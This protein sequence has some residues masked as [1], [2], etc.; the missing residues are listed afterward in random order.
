MSVMPQPKRGHVRTG[1][2]VRS[3]VPQ[4][5]AGCG[6][7]RPFHCARP[8]FFSFLGFLVSFLRSIPLA[9]EKSPFDFDYG[10]AQ[11]ILRNSF[12]RYIR[13]GMSRSV[14]WLASPGAVL[15]SSWARSMRISPA[16]NRALTI[17][18]I[19]SRVQIS[20]VSDTGSITHT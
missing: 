4:F 7:L 16:L 6:K 5:G 19:R 17:F 20:P 2:A 8:Y 9:I 14:T 3:I 1:A 13:E 12:R 18:S 11:Q 10:S 15:Q